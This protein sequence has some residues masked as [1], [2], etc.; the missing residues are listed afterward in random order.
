MWYH[1]DFHNRFGQDSLTP[2]MLDQAQQYIN[3]AAS[4]RNPLAVYY[5][6]SF[7]QTRAGYVGM[8]VLTNTAT[9]ATILLTITEPIFISPFVTGKCSD[10][11]SGFIG[12]N[13]KFFLCAFI[14]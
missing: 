11:T 1:N 2:S 8:Q 7:E 9:S 14:S 12:V 3:S 6:N 13:E 5:D 4:V 10:Y